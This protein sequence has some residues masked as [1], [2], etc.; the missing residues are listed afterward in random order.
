MSK[1][2][3]TEEFQKELDQIFGDDSFEVL[4]EYI[5][6]QIKIKLKCNKSGNII[7]KKPVKMVSGKE[8]LNRRSRTDKVQ[9]KRQNKRLIL[10]RKWHKT[11]KTPLFSKKDFCNILTSELQVNTE[12]TA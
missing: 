3:T 9:E 10:S 12:I 1:K 5:T 6:N 7:Y 2:K 11:S 8:P 4:S